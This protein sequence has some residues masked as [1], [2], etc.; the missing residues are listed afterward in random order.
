MAEL[1]KQKVALT[2]LLRNTI[3]ILRK[4]YNINGITLSKELNKGASYISQIESG[5][6]KD[7][8]YD[9]IHNIIQRIT[10]NYNNEYDIFIKNY[11]LNIIKTLSKKECFNESWIRIYI[12]QDMP[13]D[14]P[15]DLV[16]LIK[17]KMEQVHCTPQKLVRKINRNERWSSGFLQSCG[18]I[19]GKLVLKN[20]FELMIYDLPENYV[21]Q[22]IN[23]ELTSTSY[24][25]M[26][27]ILS[28]LYSLV[29]I[30]EYTKEPFVPDIILF[31]Y[32]F[33]NL[34]ELHEQIQGKV[35]VQIPFNVEK[36]DTDNPIIFY[37]EILVNYN[38][39]YNDLKKE[40]LEKIAYGC[41]AYKEENPAFACDKIEQIIN[42]LNCDLG[43]IISILSSDL[44]N[45]HPLYKRTFWDEYKKLVQ[46]FSKDNMDS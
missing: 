9:M 21:D 12:L 44:S 11:I 16:E 27:G 18:Y 25:N 31:D 40:V 34:E 29:P 26:K 42:N 45:L 30:D 23:K 28:A 39:K 3:K 14:I 7:I 17:A 15:D 36:K 1:K 38:N 22:I 33:Y 8:E 6:I 19:K 4:E 43:L 41:D 24:L 37:D 35:Q 46:R 2:E 32:G 13:V 20:A 5:K 10:N